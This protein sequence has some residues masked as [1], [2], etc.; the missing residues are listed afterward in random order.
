MSLLEFTDNEGNLNL[1]NKLYSFFIPLSLYNELIKGK[2]TLLLL[3]TGIFSYFI[4]QYPNRLITSNFVIFTIGLFFA[5]SGSTLLNMY[6]DRNIDAIM[7]RTKHRALPS[8]KIKPSTVLFHG[9]IFII[10]SVFVISVFINVLTAII[11]LVGSI[12]NVVIYSLLLKRRTRFSIL[13]GGIAGGMPALAGRTAVLNYID[14]V[15]ILLAFFVLFWVPIHILSLTLIPLNLN[16]YK[17]AKIPMWP[18]AGSK[19]QTNRVIALGA[20]LSASSIL[21]VSLEISL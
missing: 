15:G 17:K 19:S 10:S 11:I 14:L 9:Y 20:I 13:F 18:I 5:I 8:G 4:T 21:W 3:Y 16:G 7:D 1:K 2:Q 6:I 12:F